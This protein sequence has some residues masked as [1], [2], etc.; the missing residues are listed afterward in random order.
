LNFTLFPYLFPGV[1]L[2][3][4]A[5]QHGRHCGLKNIY[6]CPALPGDKAAATVPHGMM[7]RIAQAACMSEVRFSRARLAAAPG[8]C[9]DCQHVKSF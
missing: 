7:T 9:D 3:T 4:P 2:D 1:A 5:W 6:D 8:R